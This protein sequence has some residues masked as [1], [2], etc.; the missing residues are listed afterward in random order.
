MSDHQITYVTYFTPQAVC[1]YRLKDNKNE[2]QGAT[3]ML[4]VF[5]LMFFI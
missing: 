2:G 4:A 5:Q 3:H 1:S